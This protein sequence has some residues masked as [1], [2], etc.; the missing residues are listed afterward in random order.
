MGNYDVVDYLLSLDN[1]PDINYMNYRQRTALHKAAF[2]GHNNI[3]LLL[4]ENGAD[5]RLNDTNL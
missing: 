1:R 4:L 2:G 5:P 3:A